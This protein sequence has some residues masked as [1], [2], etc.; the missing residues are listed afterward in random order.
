MARVEMYRSK[1]DVRAHKS[2]DAN[3]LDFTLVYYDQ[4]HIPP[5]SLLTRRSGFQATRKK[6]CSLQ[7]YA[8][9]RSAEILQ[10][11]S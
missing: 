7:L 3:G 10:R 6:F 11:S 5:S 8:K 9:L 1:L 2:T 4:P